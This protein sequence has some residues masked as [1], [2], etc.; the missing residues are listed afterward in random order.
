MSGRVDMHN[1]HP[2]IQCGR[3]DRVNG[4]MLPFSF[5]HLNEN[6]LSRLER[7]DPITGCLRAGEVELAE[8]RIGLLIPTLH[9]SLMDS[10]KHGIEDEEYDEDELLH[11][12]LFHQ[13]FE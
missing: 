7:I 3:T 8:K 2:M 9:A 11:K 1:R 4:E 13:L 5:E 6:Y 12:S 10:Q